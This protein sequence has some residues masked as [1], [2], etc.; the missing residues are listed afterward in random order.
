[1][2]LKHNKHEV[3]LFHVLD[4]AKE[5]EFDFDNKPTEFVDLESGKKV[6]LHPNEI[7]TTY[8]TKINER[9]KALKL[10][11]SQFKIDYIEADINAGIDFT[12]QQYLIKRSKII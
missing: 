10:K 2:H 1:M 3:I 4:K 9:L 6:K 7:K 11:C 12:L 5:V 8:Q